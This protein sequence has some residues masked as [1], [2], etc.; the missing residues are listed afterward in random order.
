MDY[1]QLE[2]LLTICLLVAKF[3]DISLH[4]QKDSSTEIDYGGS[5]F[6]FFIFNTYNY[7]LID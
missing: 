5:T 6:D 3:T 1:K 2:H 7:R 4:K